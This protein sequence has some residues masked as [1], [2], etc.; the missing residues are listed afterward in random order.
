MRVALLSVPRVI[1]F[2]LGWLF[3]SVCKRVTNQ[4][5]PSEMPTKVSV[6]WLAFPVLSGVKRV[7]IPRIY[8]QARLHWGRRDAGG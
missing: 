3:I 6:S 1:G 8:I 4:P 5:N 7:T 2:Y